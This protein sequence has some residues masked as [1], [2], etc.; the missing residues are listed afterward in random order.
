MQTHYTI[1]LRATD[2]NS[3]ICRNITKSF[4]LI[5]SMLLLSFSLKA[6]V[7]LTVNNTGC[8]GIK[9]YKKNNGYEYYQNSI[10]PGS[11]CVY[12]QC[13]FYQEW[14]FRK[15]TGEYINSYTTTNS[16]TQNHSL[17]SGGCSSGGN[18]CDAQLAH[19]N[20]NA[21]SAGNSYAEFTPSISSPS[22]FVTVNASIFSNLGDHSCNYGQSGYGMCHGITDGC[23]FNNNDNNA[24]KFSVTIKPVTGNKATLSRVA[25]Y[26]SAPA[27]Y[28]WVSGGSGDNDPPA[29]FG[30]RVTKNGTEIF[31]QIDIPTKAA[32][33]LESLDFSTDPDFTVTDQTTFSF[34]ILGY[35]RQGSYGYAV[36]DVD[37]I[38]VF[39]CSQTFDPCGANNYEV[40]C[41]KRINDGAWT[42][43]ADCAVSECPG[44]KVILSVNPN[45]YPTTWTG[46][47]GFTAN[48]ND[49]L[50]SNSVKLINAGNYTATVNVNGCIKSKSITLEVR[51][52]DGDNIC[53]ENDCQPN[54]PAFPALPFTPCNDGNANTNNDAVTADGCGCAGIPIDPCANLGGDSDGDGICNANDCQPNNAN[55]PATPGSP[56]D[57]A[58]PNTNNDKI[59]ADGCSCAGTPIDPCAA[60]GGDTDGDGICNANDCQPNNANLPATPGSP[61]DDANPNTN[62][63]K[64]S[65]DGC[66]CA[67][68]PVNNPCD[69]VLMGG[70]IGFGANCASSAVACNGVAPFIEN[71]YSPI[72]GTGAF[73]IV[74]LKATNNPSCLPPTVTQANIA[75]DPFWK[76]IQGANGLTL[77]P[78]IITERTCFLRCVRRVGCYTMIESNIIFIDVDPTCS[79]PNCS[80]GVSIVTGDGNATVS[81]LDG[82]PITSLQIFDA[83]WQ[84]K[85]S[86]FNNC[87]ASQTV[88]LPAGSYYVSTKYYTAA[89]A[90]ICEKFETITV[91]VACTDTDGDG[92]CDDADCQPNNPAYPATPGSPC[93]DGNANTN[94]DVVTAN[95]CGCAG[96]P[97]DPCAALGGDSDGDGVC[98]QNDCQPN[99]PAYPATPGSPCNDGNAN[100]NND[101]VTANGCGCAGTPI[102]PC[103]ALGGDSDGDGVCNQ[104]DCQ[105]NNPAYPATPGSSCNDGNANTTNDKVTANGCGC[106]GTP[107]GPNCALIPDNLNGLI[108]MGTYNGSKYYCSS[109]SSNTWTQAKAVAAATGMGGHLVIINN[110]GENEFVRSKIMASTVWLGLTDAAVEGSFKWVDGTVPTYT[111]WASGEPNNLSINSCTN[112]DYAILDKT[113]GQWKDRAG[114][115]AYEFVIEIPCPS[116]ADANN[117]PG[118]TPPSQTPNCSNIVITGGIGKITVTGLSGAP[119]ASLKIFNAWGTQVFSCT[120]TCGASQSVA[121]GC[122]TYTVKAK[123]FDAAG[124]L[125]C[126]KI[127]TATVS[128]ALMGYG[129]F[130]FDVI[131]QEDHAELIWKH[132]GG[133][134]VLTYSIERSTDGINFEPLTVQDS[135]GGNSVEIYEDYDFEPASGDNHYRLRL[136]LTD[137][138]TEYSEVQTISYAVLEKL[139]VFPNPANSFVKANLED[140]IGKQDVTITLFNNQGIQVKQYQIDE[141]YGKYYQMDL[142]ELQEGLYVIWFNIPGH[143]PVAKHLMIGKL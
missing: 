109:T 74:W 134:D 52:T 40:E 101:A 72:G 12:H 141:V 36:W 120:G 99:N 23:S 39:G 123:Y 121:L 59:S 111:N 14:V 96:T 117:C 27:N 51:D 24:Y 107:V 133:M 116:C 103:A 114:T 44:S 137:G 8:V 142:R 115:D 31:K 110:S 60:L 93:N 77:D 47:N 56:C 81:G 9:V 132:N 135:R 29:K 136:E 16:Y 45:G 139:T 13:A 30:V 49:I 34:E 6:T 7:T 112:A 57:D 2:D 126:E 79:Q 62:N 1:A 38:K 143:R 75:N 21:C 113:S 118:F 125:I 122:G 15:T 95:G 129:Q 61:C 53:N 35:C 17:N 83:N 88:A 3:S 138:R 46:P 90:Q 124:S 130:D 87:G 89:Y 140:Y 106:A 26:E 54:N 64:I 66:S 127:Q 41:E 102:D 92:T 5:F 37:E 42:T 71:C 67:G 50:V 65:A 22:G 104:N 68:T 25:F 18:G 63:D 73:E 100:T 119:S 70:N 84:S 94:N 48:T 10:N 105:P 32:W 20:L 43:L 76:M 97:I 58:N 98:N 78:G 131:K 69:N 82:A 11:N 85:F 128:T 108:L 4:L 28:T 19:W 55:L 91:T 80:T 86:C 33:T